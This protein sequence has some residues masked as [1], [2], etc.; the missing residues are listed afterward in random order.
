MPHATAFSNYLHYIDDNL[1][2]YLFSIRFDGPRLGAGHN[3]G[4]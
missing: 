1:D 4:H 2:K 3:S